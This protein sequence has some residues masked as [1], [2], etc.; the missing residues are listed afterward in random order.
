MYMM[1]NAEAA[2]GLNASLRNYTASLLN[3]IGQKKR[4]TS[5]TSEVGKQTSSLDGR[6]SKAMLERGMDAERHDFL[7][8]LGKAKVSEDTN[9]LEI[10][11]KGF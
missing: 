2:R 5:Q 8:R 6:N 1:A 10:F 7:Q 11:R 3:L 4:R 9:D